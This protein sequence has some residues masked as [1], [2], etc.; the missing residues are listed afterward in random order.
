MRSI[1]PAVTS[2]FPE[3]EPEAA[4]HYADHWQRL[5]EER[6]FRLDQLEALGDEACTTPR[7]D[8]VNRL[9]R[10]SATAVL[11]NVE[12]ALTRMAEGRYGR[13]DLCGRGIDAHRLAVLPMTSMCA[14]CHYVDDHR[15][16][17]AAKACPARV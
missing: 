11:A 2:R 5:Q 15:E 14:Q 1:S 12:T 10:R 6:R 17:A 8:E 3:L 7:H 16:R 9:L 13:C 4:H